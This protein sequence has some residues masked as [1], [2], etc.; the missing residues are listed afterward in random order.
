MSRIRP[1]LVIALSLFM[2]T[3]LLATSVVAKSY[4][5]WSPAQSI[6]S[7]PGSSSMVNTPDLDGCPILAPDGLSLYIASNRSGG[8]GGIDIW[9]SQR[10]STDVGFGTPVNL[11]APVNSSASDFCPTPV[12]G[13]GLFFVSNRAGGCGTGADI[14]FSRE[15][16][17]HGWADP[18]HLGCEVNSAAD[19]FSPSYVEEN[20]TGV[21]YFSSS[22]TGVH[23]IYRSVQQ[24][25]GSFAPPSAVNELNSAS[26]DARPNMRKDG[27]EIV[28]DSTRPGGLGGPDIWAA[29]RDSVDDPWSPPVN[30]GNAINSAGPETRASLSWDGETLV[31][32]SVREG[33]KG[34]SDIYFSTRDKVTG[35]N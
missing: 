5:E 25:D 29:T 4:S 16:P 24:A 17:V 2:L 8:A 6:E 3:A 7:L 32:G 13:K 30:L 28:F 21:L 11:G 18:V 35:G 26:D 33:G 15:H 19:E 14:Y 22:R 9:R 12:R 34:S 20:G 10:N 27:R 23:N 1:R 31:F